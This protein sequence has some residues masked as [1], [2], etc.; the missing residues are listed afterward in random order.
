MSSSVLAGLLI[1]VAMPWIWLLFQRLWQGS[2]LEEAGE[3]IAL[4]QSRGFVLDPGGFRAR[5]V[6]RG[7]LSGEPAVLE[8]GG[9]PMGTWSRLRVGGVRRTLPLLTSSVEL[10][11]LLDQGRSTS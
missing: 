10:A 1:A 2:L 7:E 3:A 9:G 5:L 11:A 8:W 6:A 4:A